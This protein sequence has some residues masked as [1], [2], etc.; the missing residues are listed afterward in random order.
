MNPGHLVW[1]DFLPI[2]TLLTMFQLDTADREAFLL[3]YTLSDGERGLWASCDLRDENT[4]KCEKMMNKFLP[5]MLANNFPYNFTNN[6]K[7]DFQPKEPGVSELVCGKTAVAGV[8]GLTDHGVA[9]KHGWEAKDYKTVHNQGRGKLFYDFRNFMIRNL[10]LSSGS[11]PNGGPHRIVVSL[12]S[13]RRKFPFTKQAKLIRNEFGDSVKLETYEFSEY[14]VEEQI[15]IVS[16]A[17]IYITLCGG[18]TCCIILHC[19]ALC[20][21]LFKCCVQ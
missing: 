21:V 8:G 10:G 1:D 18:G 15:Q 6:K 9:K 2:Y 11:V 12:Y 4:R 19:I 5:L 20:R 14:T 13:S 16:N 7:A 3:R 17:A